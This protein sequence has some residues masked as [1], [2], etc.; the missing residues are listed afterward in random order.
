MVPSHRPRSGLERNLSGGQSSAISKGAYRQLT[1]NRQPIPV[2][3]I[4]FSEKTGVWNQIAAPCV[5][6]IA[7]QGEV[8]MKKLVTLFGGGLLALAAVAGTAMAAPDQSLIQLT[9]AHACIGP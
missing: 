9:G 2:A 1:D 4:V 7:Q 6:C 3:I 8:P 5:S